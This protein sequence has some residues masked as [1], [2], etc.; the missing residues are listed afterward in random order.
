MKLLVI[1]I[2]KGITDSSAMAEANMMK[3]L[4]Y[5]SLPRIVDIIEKENVIYE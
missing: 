5:P 1:D 2:Q 4:D 3:K